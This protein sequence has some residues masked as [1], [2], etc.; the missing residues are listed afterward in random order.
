[1]LLED[2]KKLFDRPDW[3]T[4]KS[5]VYRIFEIHESNEKNESG[6]IPVCI[7]PEVEDKKKKLK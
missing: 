7:K 4:E 5:T 3:N 6:E 1:M 2:H